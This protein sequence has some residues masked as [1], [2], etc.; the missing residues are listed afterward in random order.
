MQ[1]PGVFA[2]M[3]EDTNARMLLSGLAASNPYT[4]SVPIAL[5]RSGTLSVMNRWAERNCG[6]R[7][8]ADKVV[9]EVGEA[10]MSPLC[11]ADLSCMRWPL[12]YIFLR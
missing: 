7:W 4:A 2:P 11:A 8:T 9:D 5:A 12:L 1:E 6:L 3:L 10:V